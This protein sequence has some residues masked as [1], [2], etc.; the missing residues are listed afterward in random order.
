MLVLR[1]ESYKERYAQNYGEFCFDTSMESGVPYYLDEMKKSLVKIENYINTIS[2]DINEI[3]D[4]YGISDE[5]PRNLNNTIK[6]INSSY[7]ELKSDINSTVQVM[8]ETIHGLY[9]QSQITIDELTTLNNAIGVDSIP[10]TEVSTK[11]SVLATIGTGGLGLI[12]GFGNFGEDL[13][14]GMVLGSG[15]IVSG[16]INLFGGNGDLWME[17]TKEIISEDN[18]KWMWDSAYENELSDLKDATYGFNTTRNIGNGIGYAAPSIAIGIASGGTGAVASG[19]G[20][21]AAFS[22]GAGTSAAVAG[23]AGFGHG[24]EEAAKVGASTGKVWGYGVAYGAWNAGQ[25]YLG[26]K[27]SGINP[28]GSKLANAGTRI[29]LNTLDGGAEGIVN[30]G[31][32]MIYKNGTTDKDGN[33]REFTGNESFGEKYNQIFNE[34]GGW[35]NVGTHAAIAGGL[36]AAGEALNF[37]VKLNNNNVDSSYEKLDTSTIDLENVD[38]GKRFDENYMLLSFE[39]FDNVYSVKGSITSALDDIKTNNI[40]KNNLIV[41][42]NTSSLTE[43]IINNLPDNT[44]IRI[45][46]GYT[47]E[48]LKGFKMGGSGVAALDHVTYDKT[49]LTEIYKR[50]NNFD[51]GI[52]TNWSDVEKAQYAYD[53]LVDN[54]RYNENPGG[55]TVRPKEMDGI[56]SLVKGE[57]TCQGFSETYKLLC[58]RMGVKCVT[59]GGSL[60]NEGG[61]AYTIVTANNKTFI[62]DPVRSFIKAYEGENGFG[63]NPSEYYANNNDRLLKAVKKSWK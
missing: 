36:S 61:H 1:T 46:G 34:D 30:P 51:S 57:S 47:D 60:N 43:D 6:K 2:N 63:V 38:F 56:L 22:G 50:L 59:I 44:K 4:E 15:T 54:I 40:N 10:T 32:E 17:G 45:M 41:I 3:I 14:D 27:I 26:G 48:Y 39:D 28:F 7:D 58:D 55:S 42:N 35:A 23:F 24:A 53:Y 21:L 49:E 11:K 29:F 33:Y 19:G 25:M 12:E 18:N 16:A 62:V 8:Q 20:I 37:A 13:Y 9:E 52:N 31:L 5:Y